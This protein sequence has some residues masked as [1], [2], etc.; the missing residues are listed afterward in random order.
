MSN[1]KKIIE[2]PDKL[3]EGWKQTEKAI[4]ENATLLSERTYSLGAGGLALS[5][6]V[7]SFIIGEGGRA[8]DWQAP[9]IWG[10]FL[11]CI[12]ADTISIIYA[13]RKAE[14][15]EFFFRKKVNSG[16]TMTEVEVN[17]M[18][19]AANK[20][21]RLFNII[22]FSSLVVAIIWAAMYSYCLLLSLS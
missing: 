19:D 1:R 6:T 22:V 5:F 9:V 20:G 16:E 12:L 13:K 2:I 8:I 10:L 14:K 18:I 15:L 4:D 7:V 11:C 21:I 17:A 3:V